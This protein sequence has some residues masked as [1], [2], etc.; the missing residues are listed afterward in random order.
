MD[1]CQCTVGAANHSLEKNSVV[2]IVTRGM[3]CYTPAHPG[4]PNYILHVGKC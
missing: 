3:K 2:G 1:G 4:V